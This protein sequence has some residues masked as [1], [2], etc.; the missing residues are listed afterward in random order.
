MVTGWLLRSRSRCASQKM[1]CKAPL[2]P[3]RGIQLYVHGPGDLAAA[4][5]K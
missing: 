2:D 4:S 1:R 3:D 5:D